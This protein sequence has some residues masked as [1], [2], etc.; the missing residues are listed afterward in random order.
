[1]KKLI[2]TL[3]LT[4][5]ASAAILE[6]PSFTKVGFTG[7]SFLRVNT[8]ARLQ[9][10]G[11]AFIAIS[12]DING[13]SVN[14][15][16]L[17]DLKERAVL[18]NYTDW[19]GDFTYSYLAYAMPVPYGALG[20]QVGFMSYGSFEETTLDEPDGTGNTL[21][22]SSTFAGFSYARALTDKLGFG[23]TLKVIMESI[24]RE[25]ATG[26]AIDLGTHY[27]TGF[28][29][30][31]IAMAMQNFGADMSFKGPDLD[32]GSIPDEWEDIYNYSGSTLPTT[33]KSSPYKLP[34]V[35]KIG[36]ASDLVDFAQHRLTVALDVAHPTDGSENVMAGVEYCFDKMLYLRGG[37][38]LNPD[39]A[40][41]EWEE[42]KYTYGLSGGIGLKL[43]IGPT[44]ITVD[45]A[46]MD[47][48]LLGLNH[49]VTLSYAF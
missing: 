38:R 5:L 6:K 37:Y 29:N 23:V 32:I 26:F 34:L 9:S 11:G 2:Y 44:R 49:Y 12:D 13:L 30:L 45:Y 17:K 31:R 47:N 46:A 36:V 20:V 48:G 4:G 43:G 7:A 22:A 8:S 1:M 14:P 18:A 27:N 28:K 21:S 39:R 33:F 35:F 3:L 40:Y 42:G 41:D 16:G 15:S 19:I 25:S 24:A 10:L